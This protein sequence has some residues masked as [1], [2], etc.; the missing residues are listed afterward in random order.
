MKT[1]AVEVEPGVWSLLIEGRS[2]E[3]RLSAGGADYR[4][5]LFALESDDGASARGGNG[6]VRVSAPMPGKVIRVLVELG[7]QVDAGQ[8]IAVVEAMKMQNE[9]K[10]PRPGVVMQLKATVGA[11]VAVGELLALIE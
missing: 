1:D 3:V 6:P 8:G 9:M 10:S 2:Y 11:T 7:Q 4:G 5:A